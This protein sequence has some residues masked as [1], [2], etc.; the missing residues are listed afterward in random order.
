MRIVAG[1]ITDRVDRVSGLVDREL[2]RLRVKFGWLLVGIGV[3]RVVDGGGM[4]DRVFG[5]RR[6]VGWFDIDE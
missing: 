1:D 3:M 2:W 6:K 4:M 5:C